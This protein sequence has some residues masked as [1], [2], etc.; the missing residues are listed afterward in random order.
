MTFL[1]DFRRRWEAN[2]EVLRANRARF[3]PLPRVH[4]ECEY[5]RG[6]L[7]RELILRLA[8]QDVSDLCS[9]PRISELIEAA[10]VIDQSLI[11]THLGH[12]QEGP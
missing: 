3:M 2:E 8:H 12:A 11:S 10:R 4:S 5:Q 1:E 6:Q 9:L 7:C